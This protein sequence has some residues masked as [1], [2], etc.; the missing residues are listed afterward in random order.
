MA[1]HSSKENII[2]QRDEWADGTNENLTV[3]EKKT[4]A[5]VRRNINLDISP[6]CTLKC[7]RCRRQDYLE[8]GIP[9]PG[10]DLS[11]TDFKKIAKY[12]KS[13]LFCGQ[14]SDP[15]I[16]P[17]FHDFLEI[18]NLPEYYVDFVTVA[19]AASHRPMSWYKKAFE[20]NP[21]PLW[22]F[23]IDGLP[24]ESCLYRINQDGEKLFEVMKMGVSM[25]IHVEWQYIVFSYNEDHVEQAKQMALD[26]NIL[27][28]TMYSSRWKGQEDPYQ[29]SNK[30]N[31]I[32]NHHFGSDQFHRR[33][34][35]SKNHFPEETWLNSSTLGPWSWAN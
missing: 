32:S 23:G 28:L 16:H 33:K 24:E 30:D 19:T 20:L 22:R 15:I 7:P 1:D 27:F 25:G 9:I 4:K 6:R 11:K 10:H 2:S 34:K 18:M 21:R 5:L 14:V 31:Y 17:K 8:S 29:P 12:F 3:K 26:N 35:Q 13:I